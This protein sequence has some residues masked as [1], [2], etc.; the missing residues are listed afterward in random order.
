MGGA[1]CTGAQTAADEAVK[2]RPPVEQRIREVHPLRECLVCKVPGYKC[3]SGGGVASEVASV[4]QWLERPR[5]GVVAEGSSVDRAW[6]HASV[7]VSPTG[8]V[9]GC[10]VWSVEV[11]RSKGELGRRRRGLPPFSTLTCDGG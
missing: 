11:A 7:V 1:L 8:R 4:C 5:L 2:V 10:W 6:V 3:V 9:K